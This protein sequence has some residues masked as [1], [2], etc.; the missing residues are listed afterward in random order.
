MEG[1]NGHP[2]LKIHYRKVQNTHTHT[3]TLL[4]TN[5]LIKLF[6]SKCR[7]YYY[8]L[9]QNPFQ[10]SFVNISGMHKTLFKMYGILFLFSMNA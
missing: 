8:T 6:K 4:N 3:H 9:I 10:C 2:L 5:I 7:Y 1:R